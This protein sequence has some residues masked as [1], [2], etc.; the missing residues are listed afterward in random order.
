M[1]GNSRHREAFEQ[2]LEALED[3]PGVSEAILF[4][5]VARNEESADSDVDVMVIVDGDGGR[6]REEVIDRA[7][8]VTLET[9]I[10]VS[11]KV[12]SREEYEELRDA[13]SMFLERV[14]EEGERVLG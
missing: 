3:L 4:G 5:S 11:P 8:D 13:G 12:L 14:M 1:A 10:Y 7:Y 6:V 9:G 2:F